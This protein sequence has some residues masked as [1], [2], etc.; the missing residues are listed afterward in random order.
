MQIRRKKRMEKGAASRYS[1]FSFAYDDAAFY[2]CDDDAFSSSLFLLPR[3]PFCTIWA[4]WR[5]TRNLKENIPFFAA[6]SVKWY[7]GKTFWIWKKYEKKS[8]NVFLYNYF[9]EYKS[10]VFAKSCFDFLN[11]IFYLSAHTNTRYKFPIE[12]SVESVHV[13]KHSS[14]VSP[15]LFPHEIS[16]RNEFLFRRFEGL[17]CRGWKK[18]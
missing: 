11:S 18:G 4:E 12:N 1:F 16:S 15:I 13:S 2:S 5:I 10:N 3:R 17:L 14:N 6:L 8:T 7:D 9:F